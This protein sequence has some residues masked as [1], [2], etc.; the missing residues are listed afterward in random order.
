MSRLDTWQLHRGDLPRAGGAFDVS[1][2]RWR[3]V[4]RP[5]LD[6]AKRGESSI[7]WLRARLPEPLPARDPALYVG[8]IRYAG[9]VYSQAGVLMA[10]YRRVGEPRDGRFGGHHWHL[11]PLTKAQGGQWVYFRVYSLRPDRIGLRGVGAV[12][13]AAWM[14]QML[15]FGAHFLVLGLLFMIIGLF[16]LI[17]AAARRDRLYFAFGLLALSTGVMSLFDNRIAQVFVSATGPWFVIVD[18]MP[19]IGVIGSCLL[20]EGIFGMGRRQVVRRL[21]QV[22][23]IVMLARGLLQLLCALPPSLDPVVAVLGNGLIGLVTLLLLGLAVRAGVGQHTAQARLFALG[24]GVFGALLLYELFDI[25]RIIG[26]PPDIYPWGM[27]VFLLCVGVILERRF[28]SSAAELEQSNQR[29][30]ESN[31][32]L[33]QKVAE[34]TQDL[35]E[36]NQAL[37]TI[38]RDLE[39]LVEAR[40]QQL[41]T[42]E[43]TAIVGRMIQ[44]IAHNLKTPLAVVKSTNALVAKKADKVLADDAVGELATKTLKQLRSLATDSELIA[45]AHEQIV[46]VIDTLM[47]K[48]RM[49][50]TLETKPVDLNALVRHELEFFQANPVFKHEVKKELDLDETLPTLQLVPT[51]ITQVIEN[52]VSNALDAMWET[53][54][55]RL[56]FRSYQDGANIYLAIGDS[57]SGI[58]EDVRERIFDPF[59]TSKALQGQAAEGEPTGT[60]LGLH[61]CV[62]LLRPFG[63]E[64]RVESELGVGSTFTIVVPRSC[65]GGI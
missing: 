8:Q 4:T 18:A 2:G 54:D 29:L 9:E 20:F 46:A 21:W 41:V 23:L 3:A 53:S 40:T 32:N 25:N 17:N 22:L 35:D 13:R 63:G 15:R 57:G 24:Y 62:E 7:V 65:A 27:L 14:R 43:K 50:Q 60:G 55:K 10:R 34:R 30:Q 16:A 64:I 48:C 58:P 52:L 19:F 11:L 59:F 61:T 5:N 28:R 39:Q 31:Q 37:E 38:N 56:S 33:E 26:L 51:N 47:L 45:R 44:G 12:E 42:Q 1:A 49:D 6:G 36:K